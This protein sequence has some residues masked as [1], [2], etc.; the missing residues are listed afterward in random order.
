MIRLSEALARLHLDD[1][2]KPR[3]VLEAFRLL[4]KSIITVETDDIILDIEDKDENGDEDDDEEGGQRRAGGGSSS[5][6]DDGAGGGADEKVQA[7]QP[8]HTHSTPTPPT[9]K[10]LHLT[11]PTL[12]TTSLT[13]PHQHHNTHPPS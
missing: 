13:P 2:V 10:Q 7:A 12:T 1:E 4:K 8:L 3:Y 5:D 11:S 6:D 9:P